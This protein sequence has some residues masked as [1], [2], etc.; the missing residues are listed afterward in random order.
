[1]ALLKLVD[2]ERPTQESSV[3]LFHTQAEDDSTCD[4]SVQANHVVDAGA[5]LTFESGTL[6]LRSG[7]GCVI[8][9]MNVRPDG[10]TEPGQI[11]I[12]VPFVI[13]TI[14]TSQV[15]EFEAGWEAFKC[16]AEQK[17]AQAA[18]DA[19]SLMADILRDLVGNLDIE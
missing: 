2:P 1:M 19:A 14:P 5:W 17:E 16:E 12:A 11:Y 6:T 3:V 18:S 9:F 13:R 10:G 15:V 7:G 4:I 8:D